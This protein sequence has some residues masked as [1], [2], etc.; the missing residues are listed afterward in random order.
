M[1]GYEDTLTL[2]KANA[3]EMRRD[4]YGI[5]TEFINLEVI[6]NP[7]SDANPKMLSETSETVCITP[8]TKT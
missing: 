8:E 4:G 6:P 5:N 2:M 7:N 3:D 1:K